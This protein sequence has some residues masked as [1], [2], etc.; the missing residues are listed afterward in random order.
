[1]YFLHVINSDR[2]TRLLNVLG[3]IA[4]TLGD[5]KIFMNVTEQCTYK[6]NLTLIC[7]REYSYYAA[8]RIY[9]MI[10]LLLIP[11]TVIK[12]CNILENLAV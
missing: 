11:F 6:Y 12:S 5:K 3:Q 9:I 7:I 8:V 2:Q 1:M 4:M 10:Y